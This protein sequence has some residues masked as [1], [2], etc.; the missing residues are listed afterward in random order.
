MFIERLYIFLMFIPILTLH[1]FAHAWVAH[2]LGDDTA[3]NEGRLTLNPISH[4]DLWGTLIIPAMNIF[5]SPGGIGLIGWGKPVPVNLSNLN[6]YRRD[7]PLI[8]LAGPITNLLLA[9]IVL[10]ISHWFFAQDPAMNRLLGTFAYVSVFLAV[11]NMIPLPPLD[12][13]NIV[14]HIFRMPL[15]LEERGGFWWLIALLV[16]INLPPVMSFLTF[17]TKLLL[18]AMES[19]L[20]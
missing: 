13:W 3:K 7:E 4:I 11:F 2:K 6:N 14:K 15:D 20:R 5:L 16:V 10:A 19:T 9:F 18:Y 17:V 1:E 12:G 8:A